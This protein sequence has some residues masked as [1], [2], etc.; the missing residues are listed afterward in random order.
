MIPSGGIVDI[1]LFVV[2]C[3]LAVLMLGATCMFIYC[4]IAGIR[5]EKNVQK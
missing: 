1:I 3:L 5:E 2:A 4:V